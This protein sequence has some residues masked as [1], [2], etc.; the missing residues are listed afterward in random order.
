MNPKTSTSCEPTLWLLLPQIFRPPARPGERRT[1]VEPVKGSPPERRESSEAEGVEVEAPH[2]IRTDRVPLLATA[3]RAKCWRHR[4]LAVLVTSLKNVGFKNVLR[5]NIRLRLWNCVVQVAAPQIHAERSESERCKPAGFLKPASGEPCT[6][7]ALREAGYPAFGG[8]RQSGGGN[9][10]V[11]RAD[12][13]EHFHSHLPAACASDGA[14]WATSQ[15][16]QATAPGP[17]AK[18]LYA[19]SRNQWYGGLAEPT[20]SRRRQAEGSF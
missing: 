19:S 1:A 18:A 14:S 10:E 7:Q 16:R 20:R 3:I 4:V 12:I 6:K 8:A 9:S 5:E 13:P 2:A 11:P 17:G 15:T